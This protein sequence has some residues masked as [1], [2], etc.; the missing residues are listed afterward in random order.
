MDLTPDN[1]VLTV[2]GE[3]IQLKIQRLINGNT[4]LV[5]YIYASSTMHSMHQKSE[6]D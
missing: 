4:L 2:A 1:Y 3:E 6:L 5:L